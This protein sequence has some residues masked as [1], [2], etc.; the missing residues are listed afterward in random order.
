M[1]VFG[2]AMK[3]L[4]SLL[5]R[6]EP[7]ARIVLQLSASN[8]HYRGVKR[9][10]QAWLRDVSLYL[11]EKI[12]Q[13]LT[14]LACFTKSDQKQ[15]DLT[16]QICGTKELFFNRLCSMDTSPIKFKGRSRATLWC[17]VPVPCVSSL[18]RNRW[19]KPFCTDCAF[20]AWVQVELLALGG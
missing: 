4:T 18:K 12:L 14:P 13:S 5:L 20:A 1:A 16:R 3:L 17:S 9:I 15:A 10:N 6:K 11:G 19:R 8:P 7:I 2:L